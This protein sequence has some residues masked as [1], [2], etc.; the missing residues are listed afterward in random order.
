MATGTPPVARLDLFRRNLAPYADG[1]VYFRHRRQRLPVAFSE[2]V[3]HD[4]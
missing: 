2:L 3:T 4:V 1:F